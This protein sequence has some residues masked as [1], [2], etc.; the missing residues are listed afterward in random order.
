[1]SLRVGVI[2]GGLA[3]ITAALRCADAGCAVTLLESRPRLGGLAASFRRGDLDVDTGQHVFLRCCTS[4]RALLERLGVADQ[5]V[6]QH[7]LDIEVRTPGRRPSRLRRNRLPAP[8]HLAGALLRYRPLPVHDRLRLIGAALAMRALDP[9]DPAT[10]ARSFAEWLREHGQSDRAV[11]ALWDLVGVATLNT[12]ADRASLAL[13]ATVFQQGL[14][15]DPAA[16]DIGWSRVPLG[17]LHDDAAGGALRAAGVDVRISTKA[18]G[19]AARPPGWRLAVTR[20]VDNKEELVFDRIVCAVPPTAADRLLPPETLRCPP[21]WAESLGSSPIINA[22]VVYDRRVLDA[23]FVAALD[24]PV[25][26]VFDR[27]AAAGPHRDRPPDAQYLAVSLSAADDVITRP[28][29]QLR[30]Q[31]LPALAALLPAARDAAVLDFFVTREPHATFR[32][33]PGSAAL[34]PPAR[35]ALPGLFLAG[36]WTDTG[37]PATMEGAVRSGEAAADALLAGAGSVVTGAAA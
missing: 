24:S 17:R 30:A 3:G 6:L 11:T 27:T 33:A 18:C 19:L 37:W 8:L 32:A 22:H 21:G 36:A 13:A 35:T 34:R 15:T 29:A 26:W 2:G 31:L 9:A 20:G 14:L 12:T 10:D 25:Q 28:T 7:R 16:G 23:D 5:V 4:Y 1:M